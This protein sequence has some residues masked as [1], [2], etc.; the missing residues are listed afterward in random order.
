MAKKNDDFFVKKKPWSEVKDQLLGCYLKPYVSKIL[1][2][3]KPL[4]YVDCFA[5]KGKFDDG[6]LG[7]PL[8]ALNI[9]QQALASSTRS[10]HLRISAAFIDINYA[11]DLRNNLK[12]YP[13]VK[14]VAGAYEDT[15]DELLKYKKG[16]NVFLYIDPYGIKALNCSKF[17]NFASGKFNSIELLLNM[18]SFGFIREGCRVMGEQFK[19]DDGTLFDDLIEYEPTRLD[20]SDKSVETLNQIAGGDYWKHIIV[21]YISGKID[22]Y[23]AE[24]YFSEQYCQ[25]LS[26]SFTYVL[27]MP[28][29]IKQGQ[30]T[31]YRM[32]HATNHPDG[33]LL[34]ADNICNRWE[35]MRQLQ[36]GGQMSL[37]Q[38]T[39]DNQIIDD[40]EIKRNVIKHFSQY[41]SWIPLNEALAVFF[42]KYG[43]ICKSG[44]ITNILKDLEKD[45]RLAVMRNPSLTKNGKPSTFMTENP[46]QKV[47]VKWVK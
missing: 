38:E 35:L 37:F 44:E 9:M 13:G 33:C 36:T 3:G 18:N 6:N 16:C 26:Q 12:D 27:N 5:G 40:N 42:V 45:N 28:I 1:H 25:R 29:R 31:K 30:H 47:S 32:I 21:Q 8:I 17:D 39:V 20:T 19:T 4:V 2:T 23:K 34:M 24:E 11:D 15:I 10:G 41:C 14:I 7:S 43:V 46:K 22:G